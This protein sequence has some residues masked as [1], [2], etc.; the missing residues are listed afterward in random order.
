MAESIELS[1]SDLKVIAAVKAEAE[2][3]KIPANLSRLHPLVLASFPDRAAD[4][5]HVACCGTRR[6]ML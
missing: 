1:E 3:V 4:R 5:S 6:S 2:R